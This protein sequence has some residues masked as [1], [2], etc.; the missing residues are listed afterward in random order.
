M[1]VVP[2]VATQQFLFN[3]IG[4][5]IPLHYFFQ[6]EALVSATVDRSTSR[7]LLLSVSLH[8]WHQFLLYYR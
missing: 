4:G 6:S 2:I 8:T 3:S 1:L 5:Y 7:H